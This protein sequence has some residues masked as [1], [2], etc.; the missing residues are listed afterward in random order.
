MIAAQESMTAKLCSF[1]RAYHSMLGKNKIFD[2][3]LAYDIIGKDVYDEIGSLLKGQVEA[4]GQLPR[5]GFESLLVF[6]EMDHYF[7]PIALSR[8]A[9]A[10]SV[11]PEAKLCNEHGID[12]FFPILRSVSTL[13][14]AMDPVAARQNMADTVEQVM[15]VI[16]I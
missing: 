8:I 4:T 9:F 7:S 10:G 2:D 16:K 15:R 12:A 11:T 14:E 3:Y 5:Y 6:E 1:A 13:E